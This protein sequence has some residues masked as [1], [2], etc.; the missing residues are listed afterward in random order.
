MKE[1]SSG[2][3][4]LLLQDVTRGSVSREASTTCVSIGSPC[5]ARLGRKSL[6]TGIGTRARVSHRSTRK[7]AGP[8]TRGDARSTIEDERTADRSSQEPGE[9]HLAPFAERVT[10]ALLLTEGADVVLSRYPFHARASCCTLA[11]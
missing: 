10:N 7:R 2:P 4:R 11:T 3:A 1:R 8:G 5:A 9:N 6:S